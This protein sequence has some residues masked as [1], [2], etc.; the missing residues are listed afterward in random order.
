MEDDPGDFTV[1]SSEGRWDGRLLGEFFAVWRGGPV[2]SGGRG[3]PRSCGDLAVSWPTR[4]LKGGGRFFKRVF[5]GNFSF[6]FSFSFCVGW[7]RKKRRGIFE[8]TV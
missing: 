6:F 5:V 4:Q 8:A 7:A 2:L 3:N 1:V